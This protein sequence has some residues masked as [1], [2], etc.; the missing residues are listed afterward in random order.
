M[1]RLFPI[2][3]REALSK[4]TKPILKKRGF[5]EAR[6]IS[7]WA[8]IV[9]EQ[10]SKAATPLRIQPARNESAGAV[11]TLGV[12]PAYALEVQQSTPAIL[13]KIHTY[14]GYPAITRLVIEQRYQR[15]QPLK[16]ESSQQSK[17]LENATLSEE[18]TDPLERALTRLVH[19]RNQGMTS[20]EG[21][22]K[23]MQTRH[24]NPSENDGA[25]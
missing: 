16:E 15:L 3:L 9:G 24:K 6:I 17:T 23:T 21:G 2:A 10:L 20:D 13:E 19:T 22:D 18:S 4:A 14:F 8:E 5:S 1:A 11:L 12:H 7:D 25:S